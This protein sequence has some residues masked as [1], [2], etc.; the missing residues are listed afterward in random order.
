MSDPPDRLICIIKGPALGQATG[1]RPHQLSVSEGGTPPRTKQRQ[2]CT[3]HN[4]IRTQLSSSGHRTQPINN[5]IR[6]QPSSSGHRTQ[7][8]NNSNRTPLSSSSS[9]TPPS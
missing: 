4:N 5:S 6:T 8:I 7:L 3:H 1:E 9:H 2:R